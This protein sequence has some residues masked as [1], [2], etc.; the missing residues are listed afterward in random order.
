MKKTIIAVSLLLLVETAHPQLQQSAPQR[1][2]GAQAQGLLLRKV[3]PEYP[4]LARQARVQGCVILQ[5][6]ISTDGT[7]QKL[8]VISGH[9]M[10]APAAIE[11]AKQ[12]RYKSYYQGG[13]PVSVETQITV[14]F[15]LSA[16]SETVGS[17]PS[18]SAQIPQTAQ[19]ATQQVGVPVLRKETPA[20]GPFG[21]QMGMTREQIIKLVGRSAV[22][23]EYSKN[24]VLAVRRAPVSDPAFEEYQLVISPTEGL[25]YVTALG[26][27]IKTDSF[28]TQLRAAYTRIVTDL[29]SKYGKAQLIPSDGCILHPTRNDEEDVPVSTR[30]SQMR[31]GR[32]SPSCSSRRSTESR[33]VS[34]ISCKSWTSST[35]WASSSFPGA[36]TLTPAVLWD[37]SS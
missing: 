14:N 24:D 15:S 21:F 20:R 25:L 11:A 6:V 17:C 9:P 13:T 32:N 1:I 18:T 12:W 26:K 4:I 7:V 33:G 29:T 8:N 16:S 10:L 35:A 36:K 5:A 19:M 23:Q 30:S 22:D 31:G 27:T 37:V 3:A 28:G 2:T 34:N